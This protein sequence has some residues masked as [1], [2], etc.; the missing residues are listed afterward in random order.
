[1]KRVITMSNQ[2]L[3]HTQLVCN[4]MLTTQMMIKKLKRA[5]ALFAEMKHRYENGDVDCKPVDR[6]FNTLIAVVAMSKETNKGNRA[7]DIFQQMK[8]MGIKPDVTTLNALLKACASEVGSD[9][10]KGDALKIAI[11]TYNELKEKGLK[12]G[13]LTY[14]YLLF[15]CKN[16]IRNNHERY[17]AMED[18][19]LKCSKDGQLD[20]NFIQILKDSLPESIFRSLVEINKD[21]GESVT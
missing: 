13:R 10:E 17:N 3:S 9:K 7:Y 4:A 15:V 1:M 18:V 8:Q 5:E 21:G 2:I 14:L 19:F 20:E 12:M 6:T 16:L 11:S